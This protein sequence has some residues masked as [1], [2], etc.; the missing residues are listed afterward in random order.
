ME[1]KKEGK[2]N[3]KGRREEGKEKERGRE[4]GKMNGEKVVGMDE[5]KNEKRRWSC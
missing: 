4:E 5:R 3:E 2:E 1:K